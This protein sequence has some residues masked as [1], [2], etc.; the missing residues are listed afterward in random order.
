MVFIAEHLSMILRLRID[1]LMSVIKLIFHSINL[2]K[3]NLIGCEYAAAYARKFNSYSIEILF[4][5][6]ELDDQ[7]WSNI[8]SLAVRYS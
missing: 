3:T 7:V 5:I 1:H 6:P 8:L 4:I 2:S